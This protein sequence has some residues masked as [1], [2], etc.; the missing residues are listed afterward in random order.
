MPAGCTGSVEMR[1]VCRPAAADLRGVF[2]RGVVW[3]LGPC[4]GESLRWLM[5]WIALLR[6]WLRTIM[7]RPMPKSPVIAA[8]VIC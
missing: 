6:V 5:R 7:L 8:A 1:A 3:P 4:A 2:G